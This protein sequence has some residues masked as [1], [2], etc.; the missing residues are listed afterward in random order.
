[1]TDDKV[2]IEGE[3]DESLPK[4]V[5]ASEPQEADA[6]IPHL[7][8]T[9]QK[10]TE[11]DDTSRAESAKPED[12]ATE[13]LIQENIN[14]VTP[15]AFGVS[16]SI[17]GLPLA[18]PRKRLFA[19]AIDWVF[20]AMLTKLSY[21]VMFGLYAAL[22]LGVASQ[23]KRKQKNRFARKAV[24]CVGFFCL[25][26]FS[27]GVIE[28]GFEWAS[29]MSAKESGQASEAKLSDKETVEAPKL[30]SL[31][32]YEWQWE[33]DAEQ[34]FVNNNEGSNELQPPD[35]MDLI[36]D[37]LKQ[38]GISFAW[39]AFYFSVLVGFFSGQTPGKKLLN[40]KI[41]KQDGTDLTLWEAFGRYGGYGAGF[42][43]GLLGFLQVYWD[44]NRQAIQDK[45]AGTLVIDTSKDRVKL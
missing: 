31:D 36:E 19:M 7:T 32:D 24:K 41:I 38:Y 35:L 10:E 21:V 37:I 13:N 12:Q 20:I 1:M 44:P 39:A 43:T 8:R 18:K 14:Y 34:K 16:E 26:V 30:K 45:I 29:W 17:Y 33:K 4:V 6:D 25:F 28:Y 27:L 3:V 9:S 42:A 2:A 40:I 11:K 5:E 23:L 15:Y 22:L